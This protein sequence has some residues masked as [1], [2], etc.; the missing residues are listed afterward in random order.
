MNDAPYLYLTTTGRTSGNPHQIEIWF[1]EHDG[2]Y[3]IVSGGRENSDW[4]KNIRANPAVTV[5]VGSREAGAWAGTGRPLDPAEPDLTA[6]VRAKMNAKYNWSDGLI[7][8]LR[9]NTS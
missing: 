5:S 3:Y 8:E 6:A 1:V 4:V 2:A 7:V 9:P